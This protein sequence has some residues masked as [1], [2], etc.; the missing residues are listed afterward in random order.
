MTEKSIYCDIHC[1]VPENRVKAR[2]MAW[3]GCEYCTNCIVGTPKFAPKVGNRWR[4]R[5]ESDGEVPRR[6]P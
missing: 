6:L 1:S 4:G 2:G 5:N 3:E